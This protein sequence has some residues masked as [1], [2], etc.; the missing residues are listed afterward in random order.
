M[1]YGYEFSLL[2]RA[3]NKIQVINKKNTIKYLQS[4]YYQTINSKSDLDNII[5]NRILNNSINLNGPI[6]L[7]GLDGPTGAPGL[8]G[9]MGLPGLDGPTGAPGLDGQM[10]LPGLD[11][12]TG[13]PGLDGPTGAPGLDGPTGAPG[14]D[15]QMGLPG[16]DGPTG[17]PGLDGQ[18]GLPGLAGP[19]GAPGLDGPTGSPGLDGPTGAPGLDGQMG[20]TGLQGVTGPAGQGGFSNPVIES[21]DMGQNSIINCGIIELKTSPSLTYISLPLL[22]SSQIGYTKIIDIPSANLLVTNTPTIVGFTLLSHGIW[23]ISQQ[24]HYGGAGVTTFPTKLE[25]WFQI[26]SIP[27]AN[28]GWTSNTATSHL[29]PGEYFAVLNGSAVISLDTSSTITFYTQGFFPS[30]NVQYSPSGN[31]RY[32]ATRIA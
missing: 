15:G 26:S 12:P 11:G 30:G 19:T 8:D 29:G 22:L 27:N 5:D 4:Y 32:T 16:L 9:Q 25:I 13:A 10:G 20:P 24:L 14:L 18:M 1:S 17:A 28:F 2:T 6:G 31:S 3:I 7:S 21:L 23:I